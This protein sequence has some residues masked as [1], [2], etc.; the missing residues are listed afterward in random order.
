[1]FYNAFHYI[2]LAGVDQYVRRGWIFRVARALTVVLCIVV[3]RQSHSL[4]FHRF[5]LY[6]SLHLLSAYTFRNFACSQVICFDDEGSPVNQV[7][8]SALFLKINSK[9]YLYREQR[10]TKYGP[11]ARSGS[12]RQFFRLIA[13]LWFKVS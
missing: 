12:R 11:R 8:M 7:E 10:S 4:P 3:C 1:M 2:V 5:C 9:S 13:A 6:T